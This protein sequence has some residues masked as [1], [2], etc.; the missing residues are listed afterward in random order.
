MSQNDQIEIGESKLLPGDTI[1]VVRN[2]GVSGPY[3]WVLQTSSPR[4]PL[5]DGELRGLR[6]MLTGLIEKYIVPSKGVP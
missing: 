3:V 5:T 2:S 6:D 4:I 1:E